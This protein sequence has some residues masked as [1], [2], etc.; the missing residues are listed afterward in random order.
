[1]CLVAF[2]E[3]FFSPILYIIIATHLI[4]NDGMKFYTMEDLD[5]H[6]FTTF[7]GWEMLKN[8]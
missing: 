7:F 2:R 6:Y 5:F 1:M 3:W 4:I 8:A